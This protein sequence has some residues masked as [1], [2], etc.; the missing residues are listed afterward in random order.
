[1]ED[2]VKNSTD[3]YAQ[4]AMDLYHETDGIELAPGEVRE[5][6]DIQ[7]RRDIDKWLDT[8]MTRQL[9]WL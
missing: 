6:I 4:W 8:G 7:A 2:N 9:T 3:R 5:A 1:M